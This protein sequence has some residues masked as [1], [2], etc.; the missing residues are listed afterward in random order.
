M[1]KQFYI[2]LMTTGLLIITVMNYA[3]VT[4]GSSTRT[5]GG[6]YI[7]GTSGGSFGGGHK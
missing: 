4:G 5:H 2:I 3:T 1:S 6:G 7:G